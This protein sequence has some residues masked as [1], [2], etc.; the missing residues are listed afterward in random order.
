ML[1]GNLIL[2]KHTC[3]LKTKGEKQ[4]QDLSRPSWMSLI[5]KDDI[6]MPQVAKRMG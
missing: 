5:Y 6:S 3:T 2:V 4:K 1:H